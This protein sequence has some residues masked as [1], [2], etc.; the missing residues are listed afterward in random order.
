L[1]EIA[2]AAGTVADRIFDTRTAEVLIAGRGS[3]ALPH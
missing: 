3:A 2:A 1:A